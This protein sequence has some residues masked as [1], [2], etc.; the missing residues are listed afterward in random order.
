M[1]SFLKVCLYGYYTN[2]QFYQISLFCQLKIVFHKISEN[3]FFKDCILNFTSNSLKLT[4]T[5]EIAF[6]NFFL[7]KYFL[8]YI[9]QCNLIGWNEIYVNKWSFKFHLHFICSS[10][11]ILNFHLKMVFS[12]FT[13]N[14]VQLKEK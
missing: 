2:C 13:K 11:A 8:K 14:Y 3:H 7:K 4:S 9:I 5:L 6:K 10:H 1:I 12:N